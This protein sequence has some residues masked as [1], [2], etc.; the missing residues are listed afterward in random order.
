MRVEEGVFVLLQHGLAE[1][2]ERDD[3]LNVSAENAKA[4]LKLT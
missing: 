3:A 2:V 1:D 4:E